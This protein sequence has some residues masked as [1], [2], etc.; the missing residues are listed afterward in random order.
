LEVKNNIGLFVTD[1]DNTLFDWVSYYV[2]CFRGL[3]ESVEKTIGVPYAT[4]AAEAQ[5]VF[6]EHGSIE[7]PFVVQE[8]P[9]VIAHYGSDIDKMLNECVAPARDAF[10]D[11]A[12]NYLNPYES[13]ADTLRELKTKFPDMPMVALTDAP[14]YVAMWKM[15]KLGLLEFFDSIYG[16][17]DPKI[18]T[19][20]EHGR[21]KVDPDI[22]LK[23]LQQSNFG[24]GGKI[25]VLPEEYE[26]PGTKGLKMVL[27][28]YDMDEDPALRKKVLW[29]GDNLRKDVGLGQRL[30]I[31]TGWASYGAD[32]S[33]HMLDQLSAFSPLSSV[34]KNVNLPAGAEGTPKPDVVLKSFKDVLSMFG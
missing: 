11:L 30:G 2:N 29:V 33:K 31:K 26:K 15:N 6:G 34:H 14:R 18:P 22:L 20:E 4:I 10:L 17:A 27:M 25:R 16:L 23:H 24:F 8:M 32:V 1:I 7:Y 5:A 3:L 12:D 19:S 13:V 28:D 9:S 21:V